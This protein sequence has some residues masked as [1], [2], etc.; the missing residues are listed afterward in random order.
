MLLLAIALNA[1]PTFAIVAPPAFNNTSSGGAQAGSVTGGSASTFPS[2]GVAPYVPP[3]TTTASSGNG[4]C[5]TLT[6][7]GLGGIVDCILYLL[8]K[9]VVLLMAGAVAYVIYGAFQMISSEEK[10]QSGRDTIVYGVIGLFVMVS[11]WGLVNILSSTFNLRG[12][13]ITPTQ[14]HQ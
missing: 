3:V 6:S 8:D 14:L 9:V 1:T 5:S 11:V 4:A 13:Y 2:A 10:R 12:G 7:N